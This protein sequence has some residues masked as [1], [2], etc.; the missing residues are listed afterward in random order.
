MES[1]LAMQVRVKRDTHSISAPDITS[2][3]VHMRI[4]VPLTALGALSI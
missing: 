3:T 1:T 2:E 4:H